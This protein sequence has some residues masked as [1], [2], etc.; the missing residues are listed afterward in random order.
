M[1]H[2]AVGVPEEH[3]ATLVWHGIQRTLFRPAVA[4]PLAG[5]AGWQLH[6]SSRSRSPDELC[7][8][9][10]LLAVPLGAN[11]EDVGRTG[12]GLRSRHRNASL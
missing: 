12:H 6:A 3:D 7:T 11:A 9:V 2:P 5:R 1:L 8:I 10:A 4:V